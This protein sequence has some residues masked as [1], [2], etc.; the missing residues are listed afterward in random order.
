MLPLSSTRSPVRVHFLGR[1]YADFNIHFCYYVEVIRNISYPALILR[2]RSSGEANREVWL[3]SAEAGLV[4][5]TVFGGPKSKLRSYAS[6][7][8]SGQAW[9]YQDPSK[10]SR[11]LSDF[12]VRE[13][14]PGLREL[15]ERT[16]AADAVAETV[17]ASH[18]GGGNWSGALLLAETALDAL[19]SADSDT[20]T[21]ILLWF[22][23]QWA[24][25]LGLRPEF[26]HCSHC[27]EPVGGSAL[28]AYSPRDG[29]MICS[30]CQSSDYQGAVYS[31]NR[32]REGLVAAGPGC[33]HWLQTV[34]PLPPA[35]IT[36]Y[37]LD[38]K[39][40]NET[41]S[42]TTAILAEALGKRLASWDW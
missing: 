9:V 36:R 7:F 31:G 26:D 3:L 10:D 39:S 6:P 12:D 29:G 8:H 14:R 5:A 24:G 4:R 20:C 2:S 19:S 27:G 16:M 15:Y 13:W 18:G 11:K 23:W 1:I 30:A 32:Q 42:L 25:F 17:L 38:G 22:L 34:Q 41:K 28:I 35:Q 33:R 37:T 21:R 40:L